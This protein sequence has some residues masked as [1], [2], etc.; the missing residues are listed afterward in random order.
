MIRENVSKVS[1]CLKLKPLLMVFGE[2][3][4]FELTVL[5]LKFSWSLRFWF[6]FLLERKQNKTRCLFNQR[7]APLKTP[8]V[9]LWKSIGEKIFS[10][11][12]ACLLTKAFHVINHISISYSS[13]FILYIK[14]EKKEKYLALLFFT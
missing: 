1:W 12:D 3:W 13:I 8:L 11:F 14:R 4:S 9:T 10:L 2:M 6:W 5:I 7:Q